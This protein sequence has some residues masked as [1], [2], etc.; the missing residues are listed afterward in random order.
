MENIVKLSMLNRLEG[1]DGHR[2]RI[3]AM[4]TQKMIGGN[5]QLADELTEK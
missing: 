5:R 1:K 4:L 3:E 2:L